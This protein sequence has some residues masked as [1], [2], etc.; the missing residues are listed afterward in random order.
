MSDMRTPFR[1]P[2]CNG[3]RLVPNGFYSH[4][5]VETYTSSDAT[6]ETCQTCN[7]EGIVWDVSEEDKYCKCG[8]LTAYNS[9]GICDLCG[10]IK[11][12]V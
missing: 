7:G 11:E 3:Q 9:S 1:C 6:P 10:K 5:G 12:P 8:I 2:V 4:I